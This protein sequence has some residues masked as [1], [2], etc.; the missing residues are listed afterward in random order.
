MAIAMRSFSAS[1]TGNITAATNIITTAPT[2]KSVGDLLVLSVNMKGIGSTAIVPTLS[3]NSTGWA[4][5]T[6][7]SITA[8]GATATNDN[9]QKWWY[10]VADGSANDTPT[11]SITAPGADAM[12]SYIMWD[13]TGANNASPIDVGGS[14]SAQAGLTTAIPAITTTAAGDMQI[15]C[16]S[17]TNNGTG[18]SV[19]TTP[20]G[21]TNAGLNGNATGNA[22]GTQYGAYRIIASASALTAASATHTLANVAQTMVTVAFFAGATATTNKIGWGVSIR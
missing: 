3:A 17:V 2:G 19:F 20:T 10:R 1:S 21:F 11:V 4:G 5:I 13:V 16:W 9:V 14:A 7:A 18:Q 6:S 8:L 22:N 12:L 15:G